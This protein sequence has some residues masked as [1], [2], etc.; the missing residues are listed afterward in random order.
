MQTL[1]FGNLAA[2]FAGPAVPGTGQGRPVVASF[3]IPKNV[4]RLTESALWSTFQ[5]ANAQA[6]AGTTAR[7]FTTPLGAAGQGFAAALSIA[8]TNMQEGGRLPNGVAFTVQGLACQP[9]YDDEFPPDATDLWNLTCNATIQW[10]FTQVTIDVAPIMLI[11]AGG[12]VF[13]ATADTGAAYGGNNGSQVSLNNGA[14]NIWVYSQIAV[15][16]QAGTTFSLNILWGGGAAAI[17]GRSSA[18]SNLNVRNVL[19]GLYRSALPTG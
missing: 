11:G 19:L 5:F 18:G 8:E 16:L 7:T 17:N 1:A 9:Y 13:G 14:G 15:L 2:M 6:V 3:E 10:Q 4:Q 12:G